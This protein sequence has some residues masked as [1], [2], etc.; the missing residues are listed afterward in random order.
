MMENVG[1]DEVSQ[2]VAGVEYTF[3]IG[4]YYWDGDGAFSMCIF[5]D[6]SSQHRAAILSDAISGHRCH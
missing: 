6:M 5:F 2:I 3:N 1:G 4:V